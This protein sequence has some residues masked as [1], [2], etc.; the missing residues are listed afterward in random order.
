MFA[1]LSGYWQDINEWFFQTPD[2]ALDE[3]YKAALK[4]KSIEDEN[5]GGQRILE[6]DPALPAYIRNDLQKYLRIAKLRL[7][8]FQ[9]SRSIETRTTD[10]ADNP[11]GSDIEAEALVLEKLQFIDWIL[12]RYDNPITGSTLSS[13]KMSSSKVSSQPIFTNFDPPPSSKKK[14]N[15]L[16]DE[17]VV[18]TFKKIRQDLNPAAEQEI[19]STFRATKDRTRSSLRFLLTMLLIPLLVHFMSKFIVIGPII[20]IYYPITHKQNIFINSSLEKEA[21]EELERFE[22]HIKFQSLTGAIPTIS[23]EEL[24]SQVKERAGRIRKSFTRQSSNAVKNWFADLA[25]VAAFIFFLTRSK[26]EVTNLLSFMS[27]MVSGL[28]DSAKVFVIILFTD[29]FV[30]FHSPHGWEV[31][32]SGIADHWGIA[33]NHSFNSLFIATFPVILDTVFKFW[34]FRYLSGQSP[35]SVAIY[36]TMN[37]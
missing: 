31:L 6:T 18:N 28:S 32:L 11:Y 27:E 25:S 24:E 8:E 3:A 36:K 4:V 2:R 5:G 30:G 19:V 1:G 13:S 35:S 17:T 29:V 21:L 33:E 12:E 23:A 7:T 9:T 34:V 26:R 14:G 37:E 20:D 22:R 10:A 16:I 15:L